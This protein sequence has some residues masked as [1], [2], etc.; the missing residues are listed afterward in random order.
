[1]RDSEGEPEANQLFGH[2]ALPQ[3]LPGSSP[4]PDIMPCEIDAAGRVIPLKS[5]R[6]LTHASASWLRAEVQKPEFAFR[7]LLW[8]VDRDGVIHL[9]YEEDE[10]GQPRHSLDIRPHKRGHPCL[11][12][13]GLARIAG[14]IRLDSTGA[15]VLNNA[16]GRYG[17][18]GTKEEQ[19]N[20]LLAVAKR[21][22]EYGI[23]LE[24]EVKLWHHQ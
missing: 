3:R 24:T 5:H 12:D 2:S 18:R 8:L 17:W 1:V 9:G 23:Q 6:V 15:L 10:T 22:A 13:G 16:S 19:R 14:E 20:R 21:F 11:I 4:R 7:T